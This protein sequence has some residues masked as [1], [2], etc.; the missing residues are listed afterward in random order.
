MRCCVLL[1]LGRCS[2]EIKKKNEEDKR[3]NPAVNI[4]SND[5]D[6][7]AA[8]TSYPSFVILSNSSP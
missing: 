1:S 5:E 2:T 8:R 6:K 7:T 3:S 4:F